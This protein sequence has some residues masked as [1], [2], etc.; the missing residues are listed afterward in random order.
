MTRRQKLTYLAASAA[1]LLVSAITGIVVI[2]GRTGTTAIEQWI[3]TQLV[4]ILESYTTTTADFA[5]LDYQAPGTVIVTGMTLSSGSQEMV[6]ADRLLLQLAEPPRPG[7]PIQIKRIELDAPRLNFVRAEGGGFVGWS[8][9]V[10]SQAVADPDSVQ[11]DRRLSEV[12]VLRHV[13]IRNGQMVYDAADGTAPMVLSGITT[14]L[15]TIPDPGDPGWYNF[16]GKLSRAPVFDTEIDARINLDTSQLDIERLTL[17]IKLDEGQ[18]EVFPPQIQ[19]AL[20]NHEVRG[21]LAIQMQSAIPLKQWQK[22]T[23][24]LNVSLE[25]ARV[26]IGENVLPVESVTLSGV[27]ADSSFNIDLDARLLGGKLEVDATTALSNVHPMDL[28]WNVN[29][30]KIERTIRELAGKPPSYAGTV[31]SK[32]RLG[33][34]LMSWPNAVDGGGTINIE[35]GRLVMLPGMND[36]LRL[37][38]GGDKKKKASAKDHADFTFKFQPGGIH[39][40]EGKLVSGY[41]AARVRGGIDFAGQLDLEVNAGPL[42]KVQSML[43]K[44]GALFGKLTDKIITYRVQGPI[45][46]PEVSVKPFAAD[47]RD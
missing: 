25:D 10:R 42:E 8:G 45:A 26:A 3:G 20:R 16:D 9:F 18:Y 29:E 39:I 47:L 11:R 4:G 5:T 40:T 38:G 41:L 13:E 19:T 43:G 1:V 14:K 6:A 15:D 36:L 21:D 44:A 27:L 12:L 33:A 31:R 37:V 24:N 7:T 28:T 32:G 30:I 2:T 46:K 34:D 35:D 17:S 23:M 22:G